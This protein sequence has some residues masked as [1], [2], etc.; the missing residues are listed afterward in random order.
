MLASRPSDLATQLKILSPKQILQRLPIAL[1]QEKAANAP[2]NLINEIR[3]VIH[4][5]HTEKEV[6]KKVYNNIINSIKL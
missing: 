4:S 2:E 5:L 3:E 1:A 6:I